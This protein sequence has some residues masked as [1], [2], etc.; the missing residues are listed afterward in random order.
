[1]RAWIEVE[2]RKEGQAI[3]AGLADPSVKAFVVVVGVL[4][5]LPT[6]RAR[7]RVLRYVADQLAEQTPVVAGKDEPR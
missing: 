3:Q 5:T 4:N 7:A 6:D 1:M 2:N